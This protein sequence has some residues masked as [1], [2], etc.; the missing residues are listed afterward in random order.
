[1]I[2]TKE[3]VE[4]RT[5]STEDLQPKVNECREIA[6][7][8]RV[9]DDPS[10]E[11]AVEWVKE[12]KALYK[13][14]EG[15][16]AK[17]K[18]ALNEAKNELMKMIKS[19]LVPLQDA[20]CII[21]EKMAVYYRKKELERLAE[22][23]RLQAEARML[24]EERRLQ[25]AIDTEDES[26]LDEP[27][28]APKVQLENTQKVEGVTYVEQVRFEVSDESKIPR[29]Y[30]VPDMVKIGKVAREAKGQIEIP[31]VKI[32]VEKQPRIRT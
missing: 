27:V 30:L 12:A 24:E 19:F 11:S 17:T 32:W 22:Q 15:R 7:T 23:R 4:V 21:K 29:E 25:E 6:E 1:M 9:H 31:G 10:Y 5:P 18:N 16:F 2:D 13:Y 26:V 20:E 8:L 3:L 14:I 28:I